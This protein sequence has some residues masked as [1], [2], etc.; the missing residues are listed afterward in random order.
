MMDYALVFKL[1][2]LLILPGWVGLIFFPKSRYTQYLIYSHAYPYFLGLFYAYLVLS[3][4][5]LL[6]NG[7]SS[8]DGIRAAFASDAVLL[9]GW[10]HY[11]IFDLFVGAW[12]VTDARQH[13][14]RH[15]KIVPALV[16]T[17]FLGPL[18]LLAYLIIRQLNL[19]AS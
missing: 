2:N 9:A 12:Q 1:V 15:V 18:G 13:G 4:F 10:V 3:N 7:M 8:L 17:L 6:Q 19:K 14:L 11:L 5:G 16:F